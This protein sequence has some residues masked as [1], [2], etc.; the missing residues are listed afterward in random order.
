MLQLLRM[1]S[2]GVI[3]DGEIELGPGFTALTGETGAGKT[4]VVTALELLLG[5]RADSGVIRAGSDQ[6]FVEAEVSVGASTLGEAVTELDGDVDDDAVVVSRIVSSTGRSRA[7]LGGV[8]V[9]A[10]AQAAAMSAVVTIH[11]QSDQ[12]RL[13]SPSAQR[14]ALDRF[15]GQPL[16]DTLA[17]YQAAFDQLA[18]VDAELEQLTVHARDRAQRADLLRFGLREIEA[19]AP[20]A[21][22]DENLHTE[23]RRLSHLDALRAG[24]ATAQLI[25]AGDETSL[26]GDVLAQVA[27]A[28]KA[29]DDVSPADPRIA[30]YAEQLAGA[31][32]VLADLAADLGSYLADLEADPARLQHVQERLSALAG[33]TRKYGSNIE[34]VLAWAEH[35]AAALDELDDDDGRRAVLAAQSVALGSARDEAAT[36]LTEQRRAAA[37]ALQLQVTVEL[38]ALAMP[39]STFRV[40]VAPADLPSRYGADAI[41]YVLTSSSG[42]ESRALNK[43]V[44]GGELSR[45]MLALEVVLADHAPTPVMVFDEVDAGVGGKAAVE[46]GR[47]LARLSRSAQVIV[48]TH[49]PQVAAFADRHFR[50]LKDETGTVTISGIEALDDEGRRSELSRMLAGLEDSETALAHADELLAVARSGRRT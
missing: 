28:R 29:L 21:G 49:L 27:Y 50:V 34:E 47:R 19:V 4:M 6:A 36:R 12:Q 31:S 11:G 26:G 14:A 24:A 8:L 39:F 18:A 33:L 1:R 43:G 30:Q 44:S 40:E 20:E 38:A 45:I 2:L 9:P 46:V 23:A 48:V 25:L 7:R 10:G 35:A 37:A 15:G 3:E 42:T 22:E 16:T 5:G 13:L 17:A 32:Y 41:S